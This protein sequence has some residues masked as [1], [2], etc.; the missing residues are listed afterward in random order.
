MSFRFLS[1]IFKRK[2]EQTKVPAHENKLKQVELLVHKGKFDEALHTVERLE[3]EGDI[4][5]NTKSQ[6]Q[7]L[8]SLIFTRKGE[9]DK[10]LMLAETTLKNKSQMED[11][12]LVMD[13]YISLAT[14]L[15]ELGDLSRC[16]EVIEEAEKILLTFDSKQPQ[17]KTRDSSL[18]H[19]LGNIYRKKGEFNLAINLLQ[20]S[21]SLKKELENEI[22]LA[23]ILNDIGIVHF[24]KGE[25]K[26]ALKHFQQSFAIYEGLENQRSMVK[27]LNNIGMIKWRTGELD[28]ALEYYQKCSTISDELGNKRYTATILLNMGL[29]YKQ[30]GDLNS[31][32]DFCQ[33]AVTTFE[34]LESEK[35]IAI[36]LNNIGSIYI[37]KGELDRALQFYQ[38]SLNIAEKLE[39]KHEI[40]LCYNNL[41]E[42]YKNQGDCETAIKSYKKGLSLFEE[43]GNNLDAS[44]CLVNLIDIFVMTRF[45]KQDKD[46]VNQYLHKLKEIND[47]EEHKQISQRYNL[48]KA[49]ISKVSDRVIKR[50]EAQV[51]FQQIADEE[52]YEIDVTVVAMLN[53]CELLLIELKA[54][55]SEDALKELKSL[56]K[57]LLKIAEESHLWLTQIY[58][59]QSKLALLELDLKKAQKLIR[60]AELIAEEKGL[61]QVATTILLEAELLANQLSK[62][63]HIIEQKPSVNEMSELTQFEEL[64]ERMIYKKLFCREEE[65][66]E[67]AEKARFLVEKWETAL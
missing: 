33:K 18:K 63:E 20:Q 39:D 67:Y 36:C 34:E 1:D 5:E 53:L 19:I 66:Q 24:Y 43:L 23:S 57:R 32:L 49:M 62:W 31:A 25:L 55:G 12:F 64:L 30:R 7:I 51:L 41:G 56:L 48:A 58:L 27:A 16:L 17:F 60:K 45:V 13:A 38:K 52:I 50:A 4:N 37:K 11:K 28:Q 61:N 3:R 14:V 54:S 44:L 29:I 10:G 2:K 47:K 21:L 59:L 35:E 9:Y 15:L 65:I 22:E 6:N 26:Q 8:K 46:Q 40:A 42:V